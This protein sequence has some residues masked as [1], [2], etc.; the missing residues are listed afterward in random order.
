MKKKQLRGWA[1]FWAVL[2]LMLLSLVAVHAEE[3]E[4]EEEAQQIAEETVQLQLETSA[5]AQS[6]TGES[7]VFG[8]AVMNK[9]K[10]VELSWEGNYTSVLV[11]GSYKNQ[12]P[13]L[14][15]ASP[16][17][18]DGLQVIEAWRTQNLKNNTVL[19]MTAR[20]NSLPTLAEGESLAFYTLNN[21]VL[22]ENPVMEDLSAGDLAMIQ[23]N[24][25]GNDGIALVRVT[26]DPGDLPVD[27]NII[28]ANSD[29]YLTGKM[30]GNAVVDATP[31]TVEIDGEIVLAAYDVKIY[32]NAKQREKGKTWQPS[33]KKVQVHFFDEAFG[34][35]QELNIY[36]MADGA[37]LPE[38]V[39]TVTAEDN[40]VSFEADSFSTYVV[41]VL[42]KIVEAGGETYKITVTFDADSGIPANAELTV[43][44]ITAADASFADYSARAI[45]TTG[46]NPEDVEFTHA[47]DISLTDPTTHEHI[48]PGKDVWVSVELLDEDKL[49]AAAAM[50]VVHFGD[51]VEVVESRV[52]GTTV[53][54]ATGSF[55]M[56]V[57]QQVKLE[58]IIS[59]PDGLTYKITVEYDSNSGFPEDAEIRAS[60][61]PM[62]AKDYRE[63][64]DQTASALR[65][66]VSAITYTKM[67]DISIVDTNGV[68]YQPNDDVTVT[69]TLL[70]QEAESVSNLRVVHFADKPEEVVDA[71]TDKNSVT[72]D[73]DGFSLFSLSDFTT[74]DEIIYASFG[75]QSSQQPSSVQ[76]MSNVKNLNIVHTLDNVQ[77]LNDDDNIS[78]SGS[79]PPYG[80]VEA[81]PAQVDMGDENVLLSYDIK[82]YA[83]S[84]MKDAGINWQPSAGALT[85]QVNSE[86]LEN[87]KEFD[88]YHILDENSLPQLMGTMTAVD[89]GI[90]FEAS[91]FSVYTI[92]DHEGGNVITPRVEFHFI[93]RLSDEDYIGS[94]S[95]PFT[96]GPYNFVNTAG[97]YQTTQIIKD[98]ETLQRI[99]DPRNVV[100]TSAGNNIEKYFYGWYVVDMTLDNTSLNSSTGKYNG[101]IKY[102]WLKDEQISFEDSIHITLADT[103]GN[104]GYTIGDKLTWEL[105]GVTGTGIID[106]NGSVHVYLAPLFQD[107]YFINFRMGV[108]NS[109]L[110]TNLLTRKLVVFGERNSVDVRIGNVE[111]PSSDPSHQIFVGWETVTDT[112]SGNLA[113]KEFYQTLD[114]D[115]NEIN[116]PASGTGYY[117]TVEKHGSNVTQLDL[118]PVF[119]EAR[120]MNFDRGVAGNGSTYVGSAYRLT[121]DEREGTYFDNDFF[122]GRNGNVTHLSTRTGYDLEGWYA[123]AVTDTTDGKI[124]NLQ[125][126]ADV[127]ISYVDKDGTKKDVTMHTTA[128]KIVNVD[129]SGTTPVGSITYSGAYNLNTGIGSEKLF[130]VV[131]GKLYVYR[132]LDSLKLQA[133]WVVNDKAPI[134]VIV[135][136]QKVSDDKDTVKTPVD[137]QN[138]LKEDLTRKAAD[139]PYTVKE[140]DYEIFYT[141]SASVTA[142]PDLTN[143]SGSYVSGTD[144]SGDPI[145]T[146]VTNRNLLNLSWE[147]FHYSADDV[148]VVGA[149]NPD[150]TSVYNV[151]YD[152]NVHRLT[153]QVDD[154]NNGYNYTVT[155]A[156]NGTQYAFI[157]GQFVQLTNTNG[158]WYAPKYGY[159]YS[160]NDSTGTYGKVGDK[161]Y[162][163]TKHVGSYTY[164]RTGYTYTSSTT[165]N[166][167]RYGIVNG[168][169]VELSRYGN[170]SYYYYGSNWYNGIRYTRSNSSTAAYRGS[171]YTLIGGTAGNNESGFTTTENVSGSNLFGRDGNNNTYFQLR[172]NES[173]VS[174]TYVDDNG[175]TQN[176]TGEHRYSLGYTQTGT[177][178][179]NGTR[180][181]RSTQTNSWYTVYII[182][183]LYGQNIANYFPIHGINGTVYSGYV[184]EPQNSNV[185]TTGDVGYID[186]MQNESTVFHVKQYGTTRDNHIYYYI[187]TLPGETGDVTYDGKEFIELQHLVITAGNTNIQSTKSEE[188]SDIS[189][190][191]QYESDP[192]YNEDGKVTLDASNNR[193][194]KL[195]YL[196]NQYEFT[197]DVN[198]PVN[199]GLTYSNGKSDNITEPA[200]YYEASLAEYATYYG[201]D[202]DDVDYVLELTGPDHYIFGGWY[203]DKSC[204]VPFNFNS[205]MPVGNKIV[206]AKWTP[207]TFWVKIDPDGGEIN[208]IKSSGYTTE[209]AEFQNMTAEYLTFEAYKGNNAI[210]SSS[211]ATYIDADYGEMI[212]EYTIPR[213]FVAMTDAAADQYEADGETSYYY[214]NYQLHDNDGASGVYSHVRS[215]VYLTEEE[216]V[217]YYNLYA[218]MVDYSLNPANVPNTAEVNAGLRKLDFDT[219]RQIYVSKNR[220]RPLYPNEKWTFLGWYKVVNGAM[221]SMPYNFS[222]PV[223]EAFTLRAKWRLDGGYQIQYIPEYTMPNGDVINGTMTAWLDPDSSSGLLYSDDAK[224]NIFKAPT[225]LKKN[226][227][228]VQ[229]D[230]VI[231]EGFRLVYN[232]GTEENPNWLPMEADS[233]G[234]VTTLYYPSDPYVVSAANA[235]S[236]GRIY[237]QAVYSDKGSS[238]RRP[239]ITNLILDANTGYVNTSN[240]EELPEWNFYPGT[241]AINTADH[242]VSGNP[243]QILFGDIQ[244]SADVHLYKYA[245]E[246]GVIAPDGQQFFT[247]PDGYFL[248]GFD[249]HPTEGDY[250]ATYAAD[251]VIAVER[252]PINAAPQTLYGVW[253]PMVYVTF[254]NDTGVDMKDVTFGLS[255][256]DVANLQIINVRNGLYDRTPLSDYGN[257]TLKNGESISLAFPYGAEHQLTVSGTNNLGVGKVL[258][259]NSSIELVNEDSTT[260]YTTVGSTT[261]DVVYTHLD[262]SHTLVSGEVFNTKDFSFNETMIV[263][264]KPLTVTFTSRNNEYALLLDDNY[265]GGG[266]QEFDYSVAEIKPEGGV[267]K[268][269]KLPTTSTRIGYSF[270]G[271]AYSPT[272]TTPDFSASS[273]AGN[274]WTILNLD[275]QNGGFFS[276]H[277]DV[278]EGVS[279]R[280]LYAVWEARTD[281]VYVYKDV[282]EPGNKTQEFDFTL[283]ITGR[284]QY[285]TSSSSTTNITNTSGTFK[286][287]H[288]EYAKINSGKVNPTDGSNQTA[289]VQAVIE[290]YSPITDSGTGV[291]SYVHVESRDKTVR[292]Q[293]TNVTGSSNNKF[294]DLK[295]AVTE[296]AVTHYETSVTLNSQTN[297]GEL[298]LG[299]S[300]TYNSS[301]LPK[302]E[303]T[304]TFS[305]TNTDAG[306]SVVFTN[307]RQTYDVNVSK[308]LT[309]NTSANVMFS[310]TASYEDNGV[311]TELA[312]FTVVSGGNKTLEK[313]PAGATLTITE[314][315]DENDNYDTKYSLDNRATY[316]VGKKADEIVV[317]EAKNIIFDNTLKSYPVTFKLVDQDGNP[318]I[319]GMFSL[320]SSIGSLGTE[321]YASSSSTNPP[322]G[323]FYQNDEFW[324]DTYTLTQTIIPTNYIG[325]KNSVTLTVTGK[326]G[327]V[328]SDPDNVKVTWL[329]VSDHTK[330]YL[331]TVYNRATKK[332]TVNKILNDPLLSSTRAFNFSYSYT[333]QGETT[334]VT[335]N[336]MLQPAANN[337]TGVS[338]DL[339]VP[340]YSNVTITELTTGD[341]EVIG[342]TYD[343]TVTAATENLGDKNPDDGAVFTN[344]RVTVDGT[345]TFTNTRKTV[346][347]TVSKTLV[348]T[349]AD[350]AVDFTFTA[351]LQNSG[352][353][354]IANYTMNETRAVTTGNGE[355]GSVAGAASFFLSPTTS[356]TPSITLKVPYGA[357]LTVSEDTNKMLASGKKVAEVYETTYKLDSAGAVSGYSYDFASVE[358][359]KTLAFTNTRKIGELTIT[360]NVTGELGDLTKQFTF[361]LV[362]VA[363]E[364]PGTTYA[365][366]KTATNNTPT[367]GTLTT[368]N[369]SNIF[370]LAHGENIV[371]ELPL[372]KKVKIREENG[373]YTA[374]WSKTTSSDSNITLN[375][376]SA[377]VD[378][379]ITD[380]AGATI[381]N[382]LNSVSPTGIDLRYVPYVLMLI[383]GAVLSA[384]ALRSRKKEQRG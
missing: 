168:S 149:P 261:P 253:E 59:T 73:T 186:T 25:K 121:N 212:T 243:T 224:T 301:L 148:S 36:H 316:T 211:Q 106:N 329:D 303:N 326:Y 82:I 238:N 230:S 374:S 309:S 384:V 79:L 160:E 53:E 102:K 166:G 170:T 194:I 114:G 191:L 165:N 307:Q 71:I 65:T 289:Y 313:I 288:G 11:M 57:L 144:A 328:S 47:F 365:Y 112:G 34:N 50:N 210:N 10:P 258:I 177:E 285:G 376:N 143:F 358:E 54:F 196:R 290:V 355:G 116:N 146:E 302:T 145:I 208:R 242:I 115:N 306:G 354:G 298:T 279:T 29:I 381:T 98:G 218:A 232:A 318:T 6:G 185:F 171:L 314:D 383:A 7:A 113:R 92:I 322:A 21:G 178:E 62:S 101:T 219:W 68:E 269:Q 155:T 39:A 292:W 83:N 284:Y 268:T 270:V 255:S 107:F 192:A 158:T 20:L 350:S 237:L 129:N 233:S 260:T 271:W 5:L 217:H 188:F 231:F 64:L 335:G 48:Q 184:W 262:H 179:Y 273:P 81:R 272:A 138:W 213:R 162:E 130:E 187:E 124:T 337:P 26:P 28:W 38:K 43:N 78:L 23:L 277:I 333:P 176:Y 156:N 127:T 341:N 27:D 291:T 304:N 142:E 87:G 136:K 80:I 37:S 8:I 369:G 276:E 371:I 356:V 141:G 353:T 140:Y 74:K 137:L 321:L 75:S 52:N 111:C 236:N 4:P 239:D 332:I 123:F 134:R 323:V 198:Y 214:V 9:Q 317:N 86:V 382:N 117:V 13:S 51:Q 182:E 252:Q 173:D 76:P 325:L 180:Y 90:T 207:E 259:W 357:K 345:V 299:N 193:T 372:N 2:F 56:F 135:W 190:F 157:N 363:D 265:T 266:V 45:Q 40:W 346:E 370:T 360:K 94:A 310:F 378:I 91:S 352:N 234:N 1:L 300:S 197:F 100:I 104:A 42:E 278:I 263:N 216:I 46:A 31:V 96:S 225:E 283:A 118:Y 361:T 14:V 295:I 229:D 327:I 250:A 32:T 349:Q 320:D 70:D 161:Y 55:S 24:F 3:T 195:Y 63:Y 324:A 344:E 133:N 18:A 139:Y 200:V 72:F 223:T 367:T 235:D 342:K 95:S 364:N 249:E 330:G 67:F 147:G 131:D 334:P 247:H 69:V 153:F 373:Q 380:N 85:V 203:E 58:K 103:D 254:V 221:D 167:T 199:A 84:E 251:S 340:I 267:N 66:S 22:S 89:H 163:L 294:I 275:N 19:Y 17:G 343:T 202:S 244:A 105:G 41:T 308:E 248:L 99:N 12:K 126:P 151:Y 338:Y 366:T 97:E 150:G 226:G 359:E 282:P 209:G 206:Y 201:V 120:W 339:V 77:K 315:T 174:Y 241:S 189:G 227:S 30:P 49:N 205:T 281:A 61:V 159:I 125:D 362:S 215:A 256:N 108:R 204:T 164:N 305:W 154:N 220:Y 169:I 287:K 16:S 312:P 351:L 44:E 336:F 280:T 128:I 132:A 175:V 379:Q 264:E 60:E 331:V 181:T 311:T 88:V 152:R 296:G 347:V 93:D 377:T 257:I 109:E 319:N 222:D 286:L 274:P 348:D 228:L 183:A 119:A 122:N 368:D 245:T 33:D 110:A 375:G 240:S 172:V 293:Q 246:A 297:D 35:G 15:A